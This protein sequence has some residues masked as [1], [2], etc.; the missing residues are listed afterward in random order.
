MAAMLNDRSTPAALLATRRSGKPRDLG[1]PGPDAA[2][3]AR[4][5]QVSLRL[6]VD[7]ATE[8]AVAVGGLTADDA[9]AVD[10]WRLHDLPP[11]A[12]PPPAGP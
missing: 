10:H 7:A 2:A 6:V 12:D 4:Q 11:P 1:L 5:E 9:S 8:H 3:T